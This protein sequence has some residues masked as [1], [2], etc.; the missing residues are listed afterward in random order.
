MMYPLVLD[1][2]ADGVP[3]TVTCRV[4]GF[5][6]QAFYKWHKAPLSQRDWDDDAHL[7]NPAVTSTLTIPPSATDSS[8]TNCQVE[9]SLPARSRRAAVFAGTD[10][11]DLR[12]ETETAPPIRTTRP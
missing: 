7:I 5:S 1:L 9:G 3:V 6:T 12:Q 10:L 2:A 4:L 8:P 11:L